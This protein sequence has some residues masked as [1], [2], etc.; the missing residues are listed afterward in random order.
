[1][2]YTK[3]KASSGPVTVSAE[4]NAEGSSTES[5]KAVWREERGRTTPKLSDTATS[6]I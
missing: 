5:S 4:D 2:S 3:P 6:G 1:V